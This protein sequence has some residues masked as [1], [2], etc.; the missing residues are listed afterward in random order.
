[1]KA[2]RELLVLG[3]IAV[4]VLGLSFPAGGIKHAAA[5]GEMPRSLVISGGTSPTSGLYIRTEWF[6]GQI[7]ES[8]PK[9]SVRHIPNGTDETCKA[10]NTGE[11][12][13][14]MLSLASVL[15]GWEGVGKSFHK[16][17]R[18]IRQ[19]MTNIWPGGGYFITVLKDSP[20]KSIAELKNG[21]L[22]VGRVA[23]SAERA[24]QA[25]LK[26][27]GFDF[28]AVEAAGG[29]INH[30]AYEQQ[31]EMMAEGKLDAVFAT[32]VFPFPPL[33]L[34][35]QLRGIRFLNSDWTPEVYKVLFEKFRMVPIT[36]PANTYKGQTKDVPS[37]VYPGVTICNKDVPD[38]VINNVLQAAIGDD[39]GRSI[40]K[41]FPAYKD[42]VILDHST[43]RTWIPLHPGAK[44]FYTK[45]G[46]SPEPPMKQ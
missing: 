20:I 37:V 3:S 22:G 46:K 13:F 39:G 24:A 33:V 5:E 28:K 2:K 36:M 26:C 23:T 14:G 9:T 16:P 44:E 18:N 29:I 31:I 10:V 45:H 35:A 12:Q 25:I 21:R 19:V 34:L 11:A 1:M 8:Y 32:H 40:Q 15:D 43:F 30:G 4:L 7:E 6:K 27:Y 41:L 42:Y 17:Q 38:Y